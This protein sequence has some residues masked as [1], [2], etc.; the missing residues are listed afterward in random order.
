MKRRPLADF[1]GQRMRNMSRLLFF[2]MIEEHKPAVLRHLK[3]LLLEPDIYTVFDARLE[4]WQQ[5][6]GII[7]AHR[8]THCRAGILLCL[9]FRSRRGLRLRS[10]RESV[11]AHSGRSVLRKLR[12]EELIAWS[13]KKFSSHSTLANEMTSQHVSPSK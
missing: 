12:M 9:Q 8:E 13:Q 6:N 11:Q 2:R 7:G 4:N 1:S 3:D 10:N 5:K